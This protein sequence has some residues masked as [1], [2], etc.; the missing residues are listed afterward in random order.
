MKK[1]LKNGLTIECPSLDSKLIDSTGRLH[2]KF[3][4]WAT[5]YG[6]TDNE[7][8]ACAILG[9]LMKEETYFGSTENAEKIAQKGFEKLTHCRET[10]IILK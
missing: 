10:H 9:N 8:L 7:S 3:Q 6:L 2:A 4:M 5:V 1:T